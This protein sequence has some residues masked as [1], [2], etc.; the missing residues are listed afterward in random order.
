MIPA[1]LLLQAASP[2]HAATGPGSGRATILNATEVLNIESLD[3][4]DLA[5]GTTAGTVTVNATTDARTT[6]GGVTAMGGSPHAAIFMAA[7]TPNRI[8][9][10]QIPN[11]AITLSNG[12]G[13]SMTVSNW[14]T[15]GPTA[16]R[17]DA[18][19]VA[20]VRVGARLNMGAN[21]ADGTYSGTFNV[22]INYP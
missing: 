5:T 9:I 11:A 4:G 10:V 21:Q 13:G 1:G 12:A 14:T 18:T 7:G 19:G 15:N 2:A 17:F 8:Y 3:F 6:T 20:T 22:R 16:R